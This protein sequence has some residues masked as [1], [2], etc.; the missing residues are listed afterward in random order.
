LA[1]NFI[2]FLRGNNPAASELIRLDLNA[3][4]EW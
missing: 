3:G 1:T 2:K 4:N